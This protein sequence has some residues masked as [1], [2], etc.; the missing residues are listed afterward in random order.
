MLQRK[1]WYIFH[2]WSFF[3][4]K[5][6]QYCLN[7]M[8]K[9]CLF[10]YDKY[11]ETKTVSFLNKNKQVPY[12]TLS[13]ITNKYECP[14]MCHMPTYQVFLFNSSLSWSWK[15]EVYRTMLQAF[16]CAFN[17]FLYE[18]YPV[19]YIRYFLS[20]LRSQFDCLWKYMCMFIEPSLHLLYSN[21]AHQYETSELLLRFCIFL[22]AYISRSV[23]F[24][25]AGW[26]W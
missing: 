16:L 3:V 6:T 7:V 14:S 17:I 9:Q 12:F 22:S 13:S 24:N 25:S 4:L 2:R 10:P 11:L 23:F 15:Q 5:K 1:W 19:H 8:N 20:S 21:E 18:F 26:N